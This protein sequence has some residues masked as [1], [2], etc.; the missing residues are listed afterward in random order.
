M[1]SYEMHNLLP[2]PEHLETMVDQWLA[3]PVTILMQSQLRLEH[4]KLV[5][6][7]KSRARTH[8]QTVFELLRD[9][10]YID[11]L[12]NKLYGRDAKQYI[13]ELAAEHRSKQP[14]F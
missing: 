8:D 13:T 14:K 3:H 1:N 4:D 6:L 9:A 5:D 12:R 10:N 11:E 2:S 7:A